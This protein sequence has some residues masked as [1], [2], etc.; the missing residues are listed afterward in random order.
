MPLRYAAPLLLLPAS[1]FAQTSPDTTRTVALP[2]ATVTGYGQQLPLRRTAAAVGVVE[3]ATFERF[4]QN[5]LTQAVNTLPGVRLE[6]RATA[7][8]R[9][10]VRGSTLRSPFGVRN[11]KVYYEGIPFTEASGSTPL[12]LLD[13]AQLGALEVVKGPAASV[14]GAGTGGA[15]LLR[16]RRPVAGQA[17]AQIGFSAGSYGLRRYTVAAETGSATGYFRAQY[18]RQILDGYRQNS[19]LRRDVLALDGELQASEK[20]TLSL[21]ALYSDLDYQ[22]PGSLTR[23]QFG[24]DPRQ[25]RPSTPTA[26]GTV[27]QRAAYASRTVLLGGTYEHRFSDRF[28]S[29]TTLYVTA[30]AIKTPFLIDFERNTQLGTGGRTT[31]NYRTA[32]AGRTLRLQGGGEL[33]TSFENSRNYQ[34]RAGQPGPLRYDDEIRT[35]T[36]F[37]FAQA[38]YELPAGFLLTAGASYN[39]LRYRINRLTEAVTPPFAAYQV[40]RDFRPQVSPRLALL[41]EITPQISVYGSASS[42]FSPP[43]E[44][45][46]RPSDGS[47]NTALQAERGTSYELGTRG[48]LLNQRL[49][50]DIAAYDFRLHQTIVTRTDDQGTQLFANSGNTRQ[51]GLEAALSGWL[52]RMASLENVQVPTP[53]GP[54]YEM[55]NVPGSVGLRAFASYT[56][57]HYRFGRYE[58]NG[59]DYS[60]N[61]LTGTAPH[62]LTAGLDFREAHGFYLSPTINH[63]ARIFVNDANTEAAP[64]YWTFGARGGWRRA[65]KNKLELDLFAG[66]ENA[67]DRRYSLGNDLNAFGN[68]YF[69]PAPGRN[70]YGGVQAGWRW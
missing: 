40:T 51:R 42:G 32:L 65:L 10:S 1:L 29:R 62:T 9:L 34:N 58:S 4:P 36:G 13:P 26:A 37:A 49:T 20:G 18:A 7:S 46:I 50:F 41:K 15:V 3:A 30:S 57:N 17:R 39:R 55:R 56:Y 23:A 68:R 66:L 8:Y 70:Y 22:L 27:A 43:T 38:D 64:G 12:N 19:A 35:L 24:Q 54:A 21:H 60:G 28:S 14:Y 5:A 6:E 63:Q 44:E 33:Q 31:L 67:T 11:V 52:W 61:R 25:A 47:L 48:T 53:N 2:E 45:E 69:Q 16:N 59:N